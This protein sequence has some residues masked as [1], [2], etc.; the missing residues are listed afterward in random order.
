MNAERRLYLLERYG[1][2]QCSPEEL[3]EL[4]DS[5]GEDWLQLDIR[6]EVVGIDWEKMYA[7]IMQRPS[8]VAIKNKRTISLSWIKIAAACVI[9]M[10]GFGAGWILLKKQ[11]PKTVPISIAD[12]K[13]PV[14]NRATITL[15]NG[16]KI[17]LDS[18]NNG[19]L[20]VQNSVQVSKSADGQIK[21]EGSSKETIYNTL[22]NPRGSPPIDIMLSDGTKVWLNAGSAITY[23]VA[24]TGKERS[25]SMMGEGYFEVAHDA[26]HPFFISHGKTKI[27]VLGTHFNVNAYED[28]PSIAVTLLQG[29]VK[30]I[31]EKQSG[32]I[33]PGQQARIVNGSITIQKAEMDEVMA[34]KK[35]MFDFESADLKTILRQF[36]RWYDIDVE[37]QNTIPAD[38]YFVIIR[39]SDNL[40]KVLNALQATGVEFKIENKKL[41]VKSP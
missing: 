29:S 15:S 38:K 26:K 39:R 4:D 24:F 1:L 3:Q 5:L 10:I 30:I 41:I 14:M 12:V 16:S 19:Q 9:V 13:A 6:N 21:Y 33:K 8:V 40:S 31:Y 28:E 25:I 27:E 2:N 20:A 34:W 11:E 7:G 18:A 23:P 17:F 35:G 32:V 36:S 37:Y 22:S